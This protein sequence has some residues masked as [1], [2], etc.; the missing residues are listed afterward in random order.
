MGGI[1][2]DQRKFGLENFTATA[3][4]QEE[5]TDELEKYLESKP[6]DNKP[7]AAT[8]IVRPAMAAIAGRPPAAKLPGARPVIAAAKAGNWH[9]SAL[10]SFVGARPGLQ[11][12]VNSQLAKAAAPAAA[13]LPGQ[14]IAGGI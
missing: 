5:A 12:A 3:E 2:D 14:L 13:R 4:M 1:E 10:A 7:K 6:W 11:A 9:Q 8:G